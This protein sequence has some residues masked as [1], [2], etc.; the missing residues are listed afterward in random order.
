MCS[1]ERNGSSRGEIMN[2]HIIAHIFVILAVT[3]GFT[4]RL[5]IVHRY[6]LERRKYL[7]D[8]WKLE[9]SSVMAK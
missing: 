6:L 4:A 9:L 7:R 2:F 5:A 3:A 1:S 8:R